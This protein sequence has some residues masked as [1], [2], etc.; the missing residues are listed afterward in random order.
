MGTW[1][2]QTPYEPGKTAQVTKEMDR[3]KLDILG[4]SEMR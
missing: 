3:Y 1:N 4:L 2:M